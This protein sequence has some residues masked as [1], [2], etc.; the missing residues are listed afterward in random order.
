M[1][2]S[3]EAAGFATGGRTAGGRVVAAFSGAAGVDT[4]GFATAAGC[5]GST[6]F[7]ARGAF[8]TAGAA[9]FLLAAAALLAG[10]AFGEGAAFAVARVAAGAFVR[11]AGRAAAFA[12]RA[13]VLVFAA[14]RD[15][16]AFA[17]GRRAPLAAFAPVLFARAG[18]LA[19]GFAR[20]AGAARRPDA[21]DLAGVFFV[22]FFAGVLALDFGR[23]FELDFFA[24]LRVAML[25]LALCEIFRS[26]RA[27]LYASWLSSPLLK[28]SSST[29]TAFLFRSP[30]LRLS[31]LRRSNQR[32]SSTITIAR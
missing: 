32:R 24:V 2:V 16:A 5:F 18:A 10:A 17:A 30:S 27:L 3:A 12:G 9:V 14:G 23:A 8:V 4:G 25:Y 11:A 7:A 26:A 13:D 20:P 1:A 15:F 21:A 6:G 19:F 29:S 31:D 22:A 28:R